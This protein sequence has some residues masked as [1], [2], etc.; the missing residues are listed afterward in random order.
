VDGE[1]IKTASRYVGTDTIIRHMET[2]ARMNARFEKEAGVGDALLSF[3]KR[4]IS[5]PKTWVSGAISKGPQAI[6]EGLVGDP[7]VAGERF[8]RPITG[9][10]KGWH[11]MSGTASRAQELKGLRKTLGSLKGEK[12]V[13]Q[14]AETQAK[15]IAAQQDRIRK[16]EEATS[17]LAPGASKGW[18]EALKG[19]PKGVAEGL[20]RAGWTGKGKVTKYLP[21]SQKALMTGFAASEIPGIVNAPAATRTGEGSKLERL[22]GAL[23]GTAGWIASSGR[24]GLV[25]SMALWMAA[26]KAGTSVGRMADRMR[27]GASVGEAALAPSPQEAREQLAKI[28]QTYGG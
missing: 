24:L 10:R 7:A 20:S 21:F 9:L 23:G 1:M 26:Q 8:L 22:G 18:R 3:G 28:Y 14:A 11:E 27:A 13:G 5:R 16:F 15:A 12:A 19:G 2:C 17:H 25:P 6:R 4:V